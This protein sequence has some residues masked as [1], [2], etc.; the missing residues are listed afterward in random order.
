MHSST[1]ELLIVLL[2]ST[3]LSSF[4]LFIGLVYLLTHK[5]GRAQV[6]KDIKRIKSQVVRDMP[7]AE[8]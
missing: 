2:V 3:A 4:V 8:W 5:R 1:M 7:E 6:K